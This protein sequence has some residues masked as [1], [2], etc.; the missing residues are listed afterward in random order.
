[1]CNVYGFVTKVLL[2][3]LEWQKTQSLI[4]SKKQT[5]TNDQIASLREL[6]RLLSPVAVSSKQMSEQW[7]TA[8]LSSGWSDSETEREPGDWRRKVPQPPNDSQK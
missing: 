6:R 8:L 7:S 4:R 5:V 3:S 1:M 2:E